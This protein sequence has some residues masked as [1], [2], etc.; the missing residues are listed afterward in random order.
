MKSRDEKIGE[1]AGIG[2]MILD[3]FWPVGAAYGTQVLRIPPVEL[4]AWATL[5]SSCLFI[6]LT[7]WRKELH[8]LFSLKV[9]KGCLIYTACLLLPYA[10]IFYAAKSNSALN[11]TLF[12]QSEV[13][14]AALIGWLFLKEKMPLY[15]ILGISCVLAANLLVLYSGGLQVNP[16]SLILIFAPVVFV[17]GNATAKRLQADGLGFAPL[18][19]FR[20]FIGGSALM[21]LSMAVEEFTLPESSAWPFLLGFGFLAFGVPKA[22]WQVGLNKIDLSKLTAIAF[23]YP[24]FSFIF[25]YLWLSEIPNAYQL[26]GLTLTFLG[27]YFLT[28]TRSTALS[29]LANPS[30]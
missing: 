29:E 11:T 30:N 19:L 16:A 21:L 22:L 7:L 26:G 12:T 18:L 17:F 13:V 15:R 27:I 3:G 24:P 2:H 20:G 8:Q 25:A 9:L 6:P 28:R 4:L 14:F 23:S 10:A 1:L 5:F